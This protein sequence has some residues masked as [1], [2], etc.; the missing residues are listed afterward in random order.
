MGNVAF[1]DWIHQEILHS[2]MSIPTGFRLLCVLSK[3]VLSLPEAFTT[4]SRSNQRLKLSLLE[5]PYSIP[6]YNVLGEKSLLIAGLWLDQAVGGQQNRSWKITEVLTLVIP[7]PAEVPN[8]VLVLLELWIPEGREHLT[9]C[10]HVDG[11]SDLVDV[12]E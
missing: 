6:A 11:F 12:L 4:N 8:Q 2:N 10:V 1:L 5:M 3:P 7:G 9:M